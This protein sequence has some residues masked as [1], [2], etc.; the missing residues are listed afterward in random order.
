MKY[1]IVFIILI[2]GII[3]AQELPTFE[4]SS[5]VNESSQTE[6]ENLDIQT[7]QVAEQ[8]SDDQINESQPITGQSGEFDVYRPS[9]EISEDLSVPFPADI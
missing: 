5:D 9:E 1:L 6:A 7:Q 8:T 3:A 4:E 2:A